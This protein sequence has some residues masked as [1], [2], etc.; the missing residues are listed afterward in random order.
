MWGSTETN[1]QLA[2]IK[3]NSA[4]KNHISHNQGPEK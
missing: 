3:L 2:E 4:D 1:I